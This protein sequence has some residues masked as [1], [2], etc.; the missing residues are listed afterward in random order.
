M[1][2]HRRFRRCGNA[3]AHEDQAVVDAFRALLLC[4]ISMVA[5]WGGSSVHGYVIL[6]RLR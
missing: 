6:S 2:K 1:V 5:G 3:P 4:T